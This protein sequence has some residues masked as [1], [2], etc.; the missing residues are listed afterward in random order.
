MRLLIKSEFEFKL[1]QFNAADEYFAKLI[2]LAV[3]ATEELCVS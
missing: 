2:A 1:G 3:I